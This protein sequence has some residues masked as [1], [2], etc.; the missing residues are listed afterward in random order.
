MKRGTAKSESPSGC[1]GETLK[2]RVMGNGINKVMFSFKKFR[3]TVSSVNSQGYYVFERSAKG[4]KKGAYSVS[5]KATFTDGS[6]AKNM[7][8]RVFICP[9]SSPQFTG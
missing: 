2:V 6:P 9:E 4:L 7:V 8:E 5:A 1:T 3:D